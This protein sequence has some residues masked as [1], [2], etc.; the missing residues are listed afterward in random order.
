MGL[1]NA[2]AFKSQASLGL[3]GSGCF[4]NFL[5]IAMPS[6]MPQIWVNCSAWLERNFL[7]F[8]AAA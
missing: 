8:Y 1:S 5:T 7:H 4:M 2:E 6:S 3:T